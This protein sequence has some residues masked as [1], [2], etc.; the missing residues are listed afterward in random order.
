MRNHY[1]TTGKPNEGRD[2]TCAIPEISLTFTVKSC[3]DE[4]ISLST[5]GLVNQ[6]HIE[7]SLNANSAEF[8]SA[9]DTWFDIST[10]NQACG[11]NKYELG[12]CDSPGYQGTIYDNPSSHQ[13]SMTTQTSI[14]SSSNTRWFEFIL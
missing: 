3:S 10:S 4:T 14:I 13:V 5:A 11:I 7:T 2:C 8:N 12:G 6:N 9:Y 1:I